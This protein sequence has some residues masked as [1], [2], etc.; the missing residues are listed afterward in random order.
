MCAVRRALDIRSYLFL[1]ML[2]AVL[3]MLGFAFWVSVLIVDQER[4]AIQRGALDRTRALMTAI[5]AELH[6]SMATLAALATSDAIDR[7]DLRSFH[8]ETVRVLKSQPDWLTIALISP[9]GAQVVNA[10]LPVGNAMPPVVDPVS[11]QKVLAGNTAVAGVVTGKL[12]KTPAV[13][14]RVPVYR[15]GKVAY[16]LSAAVKPEAFSDIIKGQNL[17]EGWVIGLVDADGRFVARMPHREPG[18]L[19]SQAFREAMTKG[20]S[21]WYRGATVEG[22]DTFTAYYRSAETGWVIG[23]AIPYEFVDAGA[24]R[25]ALLLA[26]GGVAAILLALL[27]SMV[28]GR[29][30]SVPLISLA[31]SARAI[32][33]GDPV[34][35]APAERVREIGVVAAALQEAGRAVRAQQL[36]DEREKEELVSADRA[37]DQF[38]A[39]LSHEM[40]NPLAALGSAAQVLKHSDPS[41]D[42]A[43]RA[44]AVVERQVA[45]MTR[46]IEDLLDI[47]RVVMGKAALVREP[48]DLG[49]LAADV[50]RSWREAGRF[51]SHRVEVET[52]SARVHA[53][54]SRLEQILSNLLDNAVKFTPTGRAIHVWVKAE[55]GD[56]VLTVA[57]E[58]EGIAP[59]AIGSMFDLFVQGPQG[60][61]RRSGGLGVG[62][63]LVKRL[64]EMHGGSVSAASDGPGRGARFVVRLPLAEV[65]AAPGGA[66]ARADVR[67]ALETRILIVEDNEDAR[68]MLQTML[69]M[70]GHDVSVAPDGATALRLAAASPPEVMI[71]DIGLP[72]MSGHEVAASVRAAP[73]GRGVYLVALSG[74]GQPEDRERAR[75]AGFDAHLTKPVEDSELARAIEA[76]R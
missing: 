36:R 23:F 52:S 51:A 20:Q 43:A 3:P 40:R 55:R 29:R 60:L 75:A 74:Y 33:R 30:V 56:A 5:D 68:E 48:L 58:G 57:D 31:A 49:T 15:G 22:I 7:N 42:A 21:G 10:L 53:D 45:H 11:V 69:A 26:G 4:D 65:A 8:A 54:R 13:P 72:D 9:A 14:V 64:V 46:L 6:G 59:E 25:S 39:M 19:S 35:T 38:I 47:N 1:L 44:R 62:L 41:K 34:D 17:P 73:W 37:K 70:Y 66:G 76:R 63:A 24:R 16:V 27:L 71:V 61:D 50:V 32:G 28:V 12:L 18:T 67:P 2:A